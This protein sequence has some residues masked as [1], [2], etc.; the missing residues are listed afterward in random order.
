MDIPQIILVRGG[1][2]SNMAPDGNLYPRTARVFSADYADYADFKSMD[3]GLSRQVIGCAMGVHRELGCGFLENVYENALSIELE[4]RGIIFERQA[5]LLV[6]YQ[7]V[8]VG[9]Y[10][11]DIIV[12]DELLL[13]LKALASITGACKSQLLNYL[14]ASRIHAG[15][16]LNFG[17]KSPEFKRMARTPKIHEQK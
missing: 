13:E 7:N 9:H 2:R 10:I 17:A 16:I 5:P 12:N 15:L 11:A 8:P 1:S 14:K 4:R 6:R 3:F